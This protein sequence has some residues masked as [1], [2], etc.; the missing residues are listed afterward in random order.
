MN[1]AKTSYRST[2]FSFP[3]IA[4][5][6][7]LFCCLLLSAN[8][9]IAGSHSPKAQ[10]WQ[11]V[12]GQIVFSGTHDFKNFWYDGGNGMYWKNDEDK[13]NAAKHTVEEVNKDIMV[14]KGQITVQ[15]PGFIAKFLRTKKG[16]VGSK[17]TNPISGNDFIT[18][19]LGGQDL[20]HDAQGNWDW[21][22]NNI[23]DFDPS[24]PN[25]GRVSAG[26]ILT[27][28]V[29][30]YNN[31]T[32]GGVWWRGYAAP[33]GVEYEYWFFPLEGGKVI[34]SDKPQPGILY[35]KDKNCE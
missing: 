5:T 13:K 27:L 17:L 4:I 34:T 15:G 7:F 10:Q 24:K 19:H 26:S 22:D 30:A 28:D 35:Y 9:V 31:Y 25:N 33:K 6:I 21:Y 18:A 2:V 8:I 1:R 20:L 11:S 3:K 16:S 32:T 23:Q 29:W 14:K 12:G